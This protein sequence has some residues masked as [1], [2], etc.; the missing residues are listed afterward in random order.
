MARLRRPRPG[1]AWAGP[2]QPGLNFKN[3][4]ASILCHFLA[5][6]AILL[7]LIMVI[8]FSVSMETAQLQ[9]VFDALF[10]D[11]VMDF[12]GHLTNI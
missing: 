4:C 3:T 6:Y 10:V 12:Y 5:N 1:Q 2:A 11:E 7:T 9:Y 8:S